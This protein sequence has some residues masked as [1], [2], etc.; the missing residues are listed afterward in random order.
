M[1]HPSKLPFPDVAQWATV[2]ISSHPKDFTQAMA[3]RFGVSRTA[4][5]MAVRQL[6]ESGFIRRSG[7]STRPTFSAGASRWISHEYPLPGLDESFIWERDFS[8]FIDLPA[9]VKNI[10]HHGFTEIVNNANDHSGGSCVHV[11]F[12]LG[13]ADDCS[14]SVVDDGIG[15]FK[16]IADTL[17]LPDM[18]LA[19]LELS[20]GKFT[21]D[22]TRHSGEGLFF[23]S[24]MFDT[25]V[26]DA[27]QLTYSRYKAW[28]D[29]RLEDNASLYAVG[30]GG[31]PL[32]T[33]VTMIIDPATARTTREV[34]ELFTPDVPDDYSF[35]R[36]VVPV[37]LASM[38]NENLVSR[39]QAKRL[40]ARVDQFKTVEL[41]FTA[42]PEIGQ[43]FADEVFRVFANAHPSVHLIPINA[44]P[45]VRGMIRRITG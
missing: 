38:G 31:Q 2:N 26:L 18:R 36:T 44:N 20:K 32:G 39:S 24:Q 15:V 25:F 3:A 6:E 19:L 27:N 17:N 23:T 4:A 30:H 40:V 45:Y 13:L 28:P 11:E 16:R 42:V 14:L 29:G 1:V 21:S 43:A 37:K 8:P 10:L 5:A 7:G 41:D 9:N 34:F 22:S 12:E 33:G 35:S